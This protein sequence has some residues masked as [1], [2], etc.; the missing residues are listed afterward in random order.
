MVWPAS[1][2]YGCWW[3]APAWSRFGIYLW[4]ASKRRC[5][6]P[7]MKRCI[8]AQVHYIAVNDLPLY[9]KLGSDPHATPLALAASRELVSLPLYPGLSDADVDRVLAAVRDSLDELTRAR[10]PA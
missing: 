2:D 9:R 1:A 4:C 5:D 7:S 10:S 3:S 8:G 6:A